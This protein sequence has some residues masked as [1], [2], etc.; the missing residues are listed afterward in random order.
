MAVIFANLQRLGTKKAACA[1]ILSWE[2]PDMIGMTALERQI[3]RFESMLMAAPLARGATP[4]AMPPA[5]RRASLPLSAVAGN[6]AGLPKVN[7]LALPDLVFSGKTTL[8]GFS[9][10]DSEP[11]SN[12][13]PMLARWDDR[14]VLSFALLAVVQRLEIPIGSIEIDTGQFVRLGK[15]GPVIPIDAHGR[16]LAP[17]PVIR[18]AAE[19]AAESLI[20][21]QPEPIF[22][23]APQPVVLRDTRGLSDPQTRAFSRQVGSLTTHLAAGAGLAKPVAYPRPKTIKE[24]LL[25]A[26]LCGILAA[27]CQLPRQARAICLALSA[28]ACITA[29]FLAFSS[30]LW[31]PGPAALTAIACAAVLVNR[32]RLPKGSHSPAQIPSHTSPPAA[33]AETVAIEDPQPA[34]N[35]LPAADPSASHDDPPSPR[36]PRTRKPK[37]TDTPPAPAPKKRATRKTASS[38]QTP[39]ALSE[40]VPPKRRRKTA[41][42]ATDETPPAKPPKTTRKK[43][44][45]PPSPG[46]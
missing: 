25:L 1:A 2:S 21:R 40:P 20:D 19:I 23:Q 10:L 9:L 3:D 18:P 35:L 46:A 37:G 15:N 42:T 33:S 16:L 11:P 45:P 36:K 30:S 34:P 27:I 13:P 14:V 17:P 44:Q 24:L 6:P 7:R 29:Q 32:H 4:T 43:P 41:E 5:F 28:A 38:G 31:L 26:V 12:R 8:A 22:N 39:A